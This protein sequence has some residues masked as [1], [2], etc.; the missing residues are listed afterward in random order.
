MKLMLTTIRRNSICVLS[1][2][3]M[4]NMKLELTT[5]QRIP[6]CVLSLQLHPIAHGIHCV[7]LA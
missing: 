4:G 5:N 7:Q 6:V 2:S 1:V 3:H